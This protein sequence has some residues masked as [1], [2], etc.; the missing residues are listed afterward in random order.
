MDSEEIEQDVIGRET[1]VADEEWKKFIEDE[2]GYKRLLARYNKNDPDRQ[3]AKREFF[4][5]ILEDWGGYMWD[6]DDEGE[7]EAD[8]EFASLNEKQKYAIIDG[9]NQFLGKSKK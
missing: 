2:K 3:A 6:Q 9:I 7:T 4:E 1:I 8:I 5:N